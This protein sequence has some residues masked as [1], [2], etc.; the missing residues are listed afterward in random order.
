M[1]ADIMPCGCEGHADN[2]HLC[3]FPALKQ[4]ADA[5]ERELNE[6][7]RGDVGKANLLLADRTIV[8]ERETFDLRAKLKFVEQQLREHLWLG[9][10]HEG[11]YGDDGEMQCAACLPFGMHDYKR[12]PIEKLLE[13]KQTI[14]LLKIAEAQKLEREKK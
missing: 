2:E 10:G 3:Q 6:W 9:H 4:K 5:L 12:E 13:V 1:S 11:Q 8:T 14:A 7:K